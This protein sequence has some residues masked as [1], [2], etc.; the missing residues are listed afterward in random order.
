M[1]QTW[2]LNSKNQNTLHQQQAFDPE[3]ARPI[4]QQA[5]NSCRIKKLRC[6]G[7]KSGCS[8][9]QKL[10][11]QCIYAQNNPRGSARNRKNKEQ[12][13]K[14]DEN[15]QSSSLPTSTSS[16]LSTSATTTEEI[17]TSPHTELFTFAST[18]PSSESHLSSV[19]LG[20]NATD[21]V[22]FDMDKIPYG[23]HDYFSLE[24]AAAMQMTGLTTSQNT[25]TSRLS[26]AESMH[27]DNTVLAEKTWKSDAMGLSMV[28]FSQPSLERQNTVTTTYDKTPLPLTPAHS[29]SGS[30]LSD[31]QITPLPLSSQ[32]PAGQLGLEER[33]WFD[34]HTREPCQCLQRVVFLLEEI[35]FVPTDTNGTELGPWLSRHKEALRCSEALLLC[36][37]CQAKPENMTILTFLT[38]CMIAMSDS[39]VSA[40]LNNLQQ[41]SHRNGP[42]AKDVTWLVWVGSFEIDSSHEWGALVRTILILQL[43]ALDT[44]MSRFK[45]VLRSVGGEGVRK[46]ADLTQKRTLALLQKLNPL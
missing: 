26:W 22:L 14:S 45:D 23:S 40:Y 38:D 25:D 35:D 46:K 16:V 2:R 24:G 7:V 28:S 43:R 4:L 20:C 17:P 1:L 31:I 32:T 15:A 18:A 10:S 30:I 33:H 21:T 6:T 29:A 44:L 12:A 36:P 39:V 42:T 5:C 9:C 11:Q 19:Q 3:T 37:Y 13:S 27:E 8:R 34:S 41:Y